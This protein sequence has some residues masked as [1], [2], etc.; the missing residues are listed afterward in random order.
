MNVSRT[1]S[2]C[3]RFNSQR[4]IHPLLRFHTFHRA[5]HA[6]VWSQGGNRSGGTAGWLVTGRLLVWSP[7]SP[8]WGSRCPWAR[9]LT[10]T[11][12]YYRSVWLTPR[13]MCVWMVV[14]RLGQKCQL[15]ARNI[16]IKSD[17]KD[18]NI[19]KTG[20]ALQSFL[21]S[22]KSTLYYLCYN[23]ID[24]NLSSPPPSFPPQEETLAHFC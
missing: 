10:L 19:T 22:M 6:K 8:R 5:W 13:W 2:V 12:P 4:R 17:T 7:A 23:H 21:M 14:R 9:H 3:S 1:I 15:N 20:P 24:N 18:K 11:A 16:I